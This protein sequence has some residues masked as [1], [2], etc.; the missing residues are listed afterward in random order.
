MPHKKKKK[1]VNGLCWPIRRE[2]A[3]DV[4][5]KGSIHHC[6]KKHWTIQS[7]RKTVPAMRVMK[8]NIAAYDVIKANLPVTTIKTLVSL[9]ASIFPSWQMSLLMYNIKHLCNM[10][11]IKIQQKLSCRQKWLQPEH[12]PPLHSNKK[13]LSPLLR[14]TLNSCPVASHTHGNKYLTI[15][16]CEYF[17]SH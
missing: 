2:E 12:H 4:L 16:A 10:S 8:W 1:T 5:E 11:P 13:L 9:R 14:K 6:V 17:C 15:K 7:K 3:A